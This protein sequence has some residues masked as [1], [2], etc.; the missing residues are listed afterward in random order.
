MFPVF[1]TGDAILL[2]RLPLPPIS[3]LPWLRMEEQGGG[4]AG[5]GGGTMG[6]HPM[7]TKIANFVTNTL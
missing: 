1:Q 4:G 2:P 7:L 6:C 5:Q 3:P